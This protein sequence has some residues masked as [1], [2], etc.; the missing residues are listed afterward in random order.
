M[1]E[2][3]LYESEAMHSFAWI[4]LN[5]DRI[6][7]ETTIL[8]FCH[9]LT[10]QGLT[11]GI[12]A[13]VNAHLADKGITLRSGTLVDATFIDA[14]SLTKNKAGA[15]NPETS[16]SVPVETKRYQLGERSTTV[17]VERVLDRGRWRSV[18]VLARPVTWRP[19]PE[20]SASA[21]RAYEE[22]WLALDWVRDGLVVGGML[23][24]VEVKGAMPK[25]RPWL[26]RPH[27]AMV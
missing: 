21:R 14:P 17:G 19:Y 7:D 11:E 18:E 5:D 13:E 23:R 26:P 1:A 2:K 12:F 8:N 24:E 27:Q 22:W 16:P 25:V 20:Q 4:E 3:T 9:R 15:R 6:A 10:R